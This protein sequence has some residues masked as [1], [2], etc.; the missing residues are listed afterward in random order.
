MNPVYYM[1]EKCNVIKCEYNS[2]GVCLC[3]DDMHNPDKLD[4]CISFVD[5]TE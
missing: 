5:E 3:C 1:S 2:N 4:E